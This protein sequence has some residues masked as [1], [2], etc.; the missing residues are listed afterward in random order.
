MGHDKRYNTSFY[1]E[2]ADGSASSAAVVVPF[3]VDC[4]NPQSVLDVGCGVG[5]WCQQFAQWGVDVVAGI[6][7]PW[8]APESFKLGP[9]NLV[10]F[11]FMSEQQP[12]RPQLPQPRYDLV[13]TFEFLEHLPSELAAGT[14]E[15]LTS[16]TDVVVAGAAIPGQGGTHHVNEQ[17][18]EYWAALFEA[19]GFVPCDF[20]RPALWGSAAV[21]PW[22]QQNSVA[23]FRDRPPLHITERA[24]QVALLNL[25]K[26][27]RLVHPDLF[28]RPAWHQDSSSECAQ[29]GHR[30]AVAAVS[31]LTI[32]P[33]FR[34]SGAES[35]PLRVI[36]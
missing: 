13:T 2:Q 9:K 4:L 3:L 32:G 33:R 1:Q 7:G 34:S 26:P 31:Q 6:D 8:V 28:A 22:Y 25:V 16:L 36:T 29:G 19:R 10:Q 14:V 5:L 20:I 11:D 12:F 24:G 18:P 30:P 17:W 23:Y 15:L 21:E 35:A 27:A